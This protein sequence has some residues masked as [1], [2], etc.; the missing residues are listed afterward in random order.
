M[1]VLVLLPG[2]DGTGDLFAPLLEEL[3]AEVKSIVVRYPTRAPLDYEELHRL[4]LPTLPTKSSFV[5]LGE[6]FS[7]PVAISLAALR[8][9]GLRGV[10]L[11][12][13]FASS[14]MRCAKLLARLLPLAPV[15]WAARTLWPRRL[16][17]RFRSAE[18]TRLMRQA[19]D[20]VSAAVLRARIK[21]VLSVDVTSAL[22]AIDLPMLY[23]QAGEDAVV[24]PRAAAEFA[25]IARRGTV[26]TIPGP[27][28][29][30]QCAPSAAARAIERFLDAA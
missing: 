29:L 12:A 26:E 1:T 11:C 30:L 3:S 8:P 4:V 25:Q 28:L 7:G 5:L 2:L 9:A 10:V 24:P 13:S 23:L 16:M 17:G 14:P 27:H 18:V 22:A 6:S 20:R 19:L 21:A 15:R